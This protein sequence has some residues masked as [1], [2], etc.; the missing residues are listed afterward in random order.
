LEHA[1]LFFRC[2]GPLGVH[3]CRFRES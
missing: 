3:W 2:N 1:V